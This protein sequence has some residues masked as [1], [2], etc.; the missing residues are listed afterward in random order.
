MD[1]LQRA[2]AM[3]SGKGRD[4]LSE[5]NASDCPYMPIAGFANG[6][7]LWLLAE[8]IIFFQKDSH[9]ASVIL[10]TFL[11]NGLLFWSSNFSS[12]NCG[13]A[14]SK[15]FV[16]KQGQ[17]PAIITQIILL[18]RLAAVAFLI[19]KGLSWWLILVPLFPAYLQS[20][21]LIQELGDKDGKYENNCLVYTIILVLIPI[22]FSAQLVPCALTFAA[23]YFI[24]PIIDTKIKNLEFEDQLIAKRECIELITLCLALLLLK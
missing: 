3:F 22:L 12:F 10:G 19:M 13:S 23:I 17:S 4:Q 21:K 11:I 15:V 1:A 14:L 20:I 6:V 16:S 7:S 2:W 5:F 18:F 9:I 8:I 24:S